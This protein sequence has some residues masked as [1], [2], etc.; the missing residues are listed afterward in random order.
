MRINM[1]IQAVGEF[2]VQGLRV[3]QTMAVLALGNLAMTH[4]TGSTIK[5]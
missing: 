3:R 1:A 5:L 4:V 2:L